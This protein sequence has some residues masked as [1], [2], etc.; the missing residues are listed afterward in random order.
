ML[1][2]IFAI[3]IIASFNACGVDTASSSKEKEVEEQKD[4]VATDSDLIVFDPIDA[5]PVVIIPVD[6]NSTPD[7]NGS[8][9]GDDI[10]P[11]V[12]PVN[13][14]TSEFDVVGAIADP[15]A[16][17]ISGTKSY[18]DPVPD[19]SY[20]GELDG[21]NGSAS[22]IATVGEKQVGLVISS[23]YLSQEYADTWVTLFYR[24]APDSVDLGVQGVASYKMD[25]VFF[26]SYDIAW[27]DESI[28]DIDNVVYVK[29]DKTAKP[30]CYRLT[31]NSVVG[32]EIDVQKVYRVRK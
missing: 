9:G 5:N 11:E 32:S 12:P 3:L 27:A 4:I 24:S 23:E 26:I 8:E 18:N 25:D 10:I 21:E 13:Q 17:T 15:N 29:S 6:I 28:P 20:G 14:S 30:S 16:C 31:L 22:A 1:K 19:A 7:E 2:Y